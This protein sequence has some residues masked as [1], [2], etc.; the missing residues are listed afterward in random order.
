MAQDCFK[1]VFKECFRGRGSKRI[2]KDY[3]SSIPMW[4][5]SVTGVI[6]ECYRCITGVLHVYYR[7]VTGVLMGFLQ[8]CLGNITEM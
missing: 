1:Q 4:S 7:S 6:Q 2:L 5:R 8:E 3:Y